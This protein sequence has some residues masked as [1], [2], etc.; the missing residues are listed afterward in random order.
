MCCISLYLWLLSGLWSAHYW[1]G[2]LMWR[3]STSLFLWAKHV[4][5]MFLFVFLLSRS[6][7]EATPHLLL[8]QFWLSTQ[9]R[10]LITKGTTVFV[11]VLSM[12]I[13]E[14]IFL[15]TWVSDMF[16]LWL[17]FSLW[18]QFPIFWDVSECLSSDQNP[19]LWIQR[20]FCVKKFCAICVR[21]LTVVL[22]KWLEI[23]ALASPLQ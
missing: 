5:L 21:Y 14:S 17:R 3:N 7:G 9:K 4:E 15:K 16:V 1:E 11:F 19:V 18:N 22:H 23:S 6:V 8:Y 2:W 13:I 10:W 20:F 12:R